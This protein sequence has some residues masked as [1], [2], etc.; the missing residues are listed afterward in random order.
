MK[1]S[2]TCL[3]R[4]MIHK[5]HPKPRVK[6][7]DT[8]MYTDSLSF[9]DRRVHVTVAGDARVRPTSNIQ[10]P[11]SAEGQ[12]LPFGRLI[13]YANLQINFPQPDALIIN[14]I[15]CGGLP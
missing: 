13:C 9:V 5:I 4:I 10:N 1:S 6:S 2:P 11:T 15:F 7:N 8:R 3:V 14:T 12:G